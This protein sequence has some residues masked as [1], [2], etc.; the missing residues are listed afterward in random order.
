MTPR[1]L[2]VRLGSLG[3]IVHALPVAAALR[4]A[5]P[6]ARLDWLVEARWQELLELNPALSNVI[7]VDT[8]AWRRALWRPRTWRSLNGVVGTLRRARYDI[9]FDLQ[10]LYKSALL[11]WLSRAPRRVGFE[12]AFAREAGATRFYTER[13]RPPAGKHVVEMNLALAGAACP[14]AGGKEAARFPLPVSA[15]EDAQVE[16]WLRANHL[17]EFFLLSPGGGWGAKRWPLERY[18]QVH[19]AVARARGWRSV[20]NVGPGE[21]A[22]FNEFLKHARVTRPV[23]ASLPLRQLVALLRRARLVIS[24]DSGPLHLAAALGTPTVGLYGPTDPAR[25]GPYGPRAVALHRRELAT[26][27]HKRGDKPSPAMLAVTVE[28]VVAAADRLL[29]GAGG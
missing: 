25:N 18:A 9:A 28:E 19:N 20:V 29:E 12:R 23:Q 16:E 21:E 7:P 22:L 17:V 10:G 15:E 6:G 27:S 2:L 24:G 3:D 8:R 13:V 14:A 11:A 1:F 26:I 5:F 4:A